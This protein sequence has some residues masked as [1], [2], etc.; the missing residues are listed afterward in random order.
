[1]LGI[2]IRSQLS[3]SIP[4]LSTSLFNKRNTARVRDTDP[5]SLTHTASINLRSIVKETVIILLYKPYMDNKGFTV[6]LIFYK[7]VGV[8]M[9]DHNE[10]NVTCHTLIIYTATRPSCSQVFVTYQ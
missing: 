4:S 10:N 6:G 2:N 1:M 8:Y 7:W 3:Q 9:T 5:L